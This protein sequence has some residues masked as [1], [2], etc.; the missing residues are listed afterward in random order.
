MAEK[1][2]KLYGVKVSP[3][4]NR[5]E[6]ALKLKGVDY[7]FIEEDLQNKSP[8]LLK[9]NPV[10]KKIP[11]LVHGNNVVAES[12]V[13][14]EY[15]EDTW[16]SG[17]NLLPQDPYHRALAR[18]WARFIDDKI[19][20]GIFRVFIMGEE[21]VMEQV[22]ESLKIVDRELEGKR[23]FGGEKIG[24]L[25]IAANFLGYWMLA[26]EEVTHTAIVTREAFPAICKWRDEFESRREVKE[27]LPQREKLVIPMRARFEAI[28]GNNH[29]S[30][31]LIV[32]K[33]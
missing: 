25:D 8:N 14:L 18:F 28:R 20:Q 13:I 32:F 10:H 1:K 5:V 27:V 33:Y 16:S 3:Y 26:V 11:V 2:V 21:H 30:K 15:I 22:L 4:S 9:Y 7:E 17:S 23:F 12:Q 31:G 29:S 24:F 19:F 6:I